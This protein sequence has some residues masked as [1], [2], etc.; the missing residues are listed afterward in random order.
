MQPCSRPNRAP[1]R[2]VGIPSTLQSAVP[3]GRYLCRPESPRMCDFKLVTPAPSSFFT[4]KF[5]KALWVP[6]YPTLQNLEAE[7]LEACRD[8]LLSGL[9]APVH[10]A[11]AFSGCGYTASPVTCLSWVLGP[12]FEDLGFRVAGPA[13]SRSTAQHDY[14]MVAFFCPQVSCTGSCNPQRKRCQRH[15]EQV[16]PTIPPQHAKPQTR[17]CLSA[18]IAQRNQLLTSR[19]RRASMPVPHPH[20]QAYRPGGRRTNEVRSS[21]GCTRLRSRF[22]FGS[23]LFLPLCFAV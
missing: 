17:Q 1:R 14:A 3:G 2:Y 10:C 7:N 20:S 19:F 22:Q 5:I 8:T 21:L 4:L 11:G 15:A 6:H 9:S 13:C 16:P 23:H 12:G 18:Q